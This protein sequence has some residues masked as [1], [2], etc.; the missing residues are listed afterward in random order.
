VLLWTAATAAMLAAVLV[1]V[2][3]PAG[4]TPDNAKPAIADAP[5]LEGPAT[6]GS[7][8]L[9]P[10]GGLPERGADEKA[11]YRPVSV[12]PF[13]APPATPKPDAR[14]A[15]P[16]LESRSPGPPL[17]ARR[18]T[19]RAPSSKLSPEEIAA[20]LAR[21]EQRLKAGELAAARLY[22]E[23]VALAG[24]ARG[25]LGMA[26]TY[27]PAVLAVLPILGPQ[28]DPAAAR[29]WYERAASRRAGG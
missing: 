8:T 7:L 9:A 29:M 1:L 28:A 18:E 26:R 19:P 4:E 22:F 20:H 12:A 3:E 17:E 5:A 27:D 24:D 2:L 11:P 10:S 25:A 16:G 13:P 15:P 6:T 21:G 14:P 23:R